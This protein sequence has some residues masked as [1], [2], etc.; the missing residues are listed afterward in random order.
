M[1]WALDSRR[2]DTG[3]ANSRSVSKPRW[4]PVVLAGIH[5][6]GKELL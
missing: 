2:L 6:R 4:I 1:E 3:A 5:F